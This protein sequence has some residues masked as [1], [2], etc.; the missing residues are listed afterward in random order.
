MDLGISPAHTADK[1]ESIFAPAAIGGGLMDNSNGLTPSHGIA[2]VTADKVRK[3]K[4]YS[5]SIKNGVNP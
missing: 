3:A 1:L 2:Q 4:A 5:D